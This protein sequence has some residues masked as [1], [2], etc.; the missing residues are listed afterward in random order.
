MLASSTFTGVRVNTARPARQTRA[1]A[2]AT[3]AAANP[4]AEELV[5]TAKY[6]ASPGKGILAID[7]SNATCGKRLDSIGVSNTEDNRRAYRELLLTTPG[8]GQY[9]SGA[10]LFEETLFQNTSSGKSFVDVMKGQGITPGIKVD[11]GL[12]PLPFSNGESWCQ[13]LDGLAGRAAQYYKQGA[14]F[15]KWRSTVNIPAGPTEAAV[16]DCAYGL[17]RYAAICQDNGLVPIVEPEILLDGDHS[18]DRTLEVAEKTWAA[19][20][21]Y[22]ADFGVMFEGI[23]LKPSMVT[24]GADHAKKS[25]PPEVAEYTLKML[26]R[27]VP[28]AV[29]GIMFLSGGQS[30]LEASLNLNAMNQKPNP[31]HVSFSYARALQN[32]VLKT[33]QGQEGNK[34]AAQDAL[35]RRA[36]ANSDAQLGKFV[37]T[38]EDKKAI[39]STYQKNYVY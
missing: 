14:R 28:P 2:V 27:R 24:P 3:Q 7:E 19:T 37:P 22:L 17:A 20:F 6:I 25:T 30:E 10:I 26:K 5:K 8:L 13:G 4:F 32:T 11:K 15:A 16:M 29:P 33:W 1:A 35:L 23:L 39:E 21:K 9:I 12:V 38:A 31:W 18:I 36:K 34:K